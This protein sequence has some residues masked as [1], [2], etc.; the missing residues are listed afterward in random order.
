MRCPNEKEEED[1]RLFTSEAVIGELGLV[2]KHK[3]IYYFD[4]G[5]RHEFEVEV[6]DIRPQAEPGQYPRVVD[7]KGEAPPQYDW[8][9][10]DEHT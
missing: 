5:D 4:Y 6:I 9:D 7:S 8:P 1:G 10:G 3:F 2:R